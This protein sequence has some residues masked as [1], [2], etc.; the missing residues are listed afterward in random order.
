[1]RKIEFTAHLCDPLNPGFGYQVKVTDRRT[2]ET[3]WHSSVDGATGKDLLTEED[4]IRAIIPFIA[5]CPQ[6]PK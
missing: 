4:C 2:G 6:L 3:I 1:M 5:D